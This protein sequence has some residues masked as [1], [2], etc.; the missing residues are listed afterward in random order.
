MQDTDI[1]VKIFKET[2]EYFTEYKV[3]MFLFDGKTKICLKNSSGEREVLSLWRWPQ[4][5]VRFS[6]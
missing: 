5:T 4:E 6:R 3:W 1:Q 2:A